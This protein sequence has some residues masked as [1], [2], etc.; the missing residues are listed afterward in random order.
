MNTPVA[1]KLFQSVP[2][3][4]AVSRKSAQELEQSVD[5]KNSMAKT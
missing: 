4:V 5:G 2:R 3:G 1:D